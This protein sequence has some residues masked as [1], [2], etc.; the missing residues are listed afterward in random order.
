[1]L[2]SHLGQAKS[3]R[4]IEEGLPASEGKVRLLGMQ[5][6]P[7]HSTLSYAKQHRPWQIYESLFHLLRES[8]IALLPQYALITDGK[9]SDTAVARQLELPAGS[10]LVADRG[11][12]D[13]TWFAEL[14]GKKGNFVTRLKDNAA[15][16]T[17]ESR[18]ALGDDVIA[19]EIVVFVKHATADNKNFLSLVR[20]RDPESQRELAFLT[21]AQQNGLASFALHCPAAPATLCLSRSLAFPRSTLRRSTRT[22]LRRRKPA[23]TTGPST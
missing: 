18:P 6:A 3:L 22:E 1:M 17:V 11:Y 16:V 19:D 9:T 10:M 8:P 14:T 20:Y 2:F 4:K 7:G 12:C 13:Y 23:P 15:Y 21:T 5:Q